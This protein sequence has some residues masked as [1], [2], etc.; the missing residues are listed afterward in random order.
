MTFYGQ[1]KFAVALYAKELSRRLRRRAIAVNSGITGEYW[2]DCRVAEGNPLLNDS[3]LAKRLWQVSM[4]IIQRIT[5]AT[6]TDAGC[7][8]IRREAHR[9][10]I[11]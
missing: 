10:S 8:V 1:S 5:N 6:R 2:S 3:D 7:S 11:Y 4:Q 9:T